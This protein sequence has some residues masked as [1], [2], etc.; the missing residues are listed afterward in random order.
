MVNELICSTYEKMSNHIVVILLG[1][2]MIF[3][4]PH[5]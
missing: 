3:C 5:V 2:R 4:W 1:V